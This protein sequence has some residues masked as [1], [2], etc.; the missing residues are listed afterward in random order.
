[1]KTFEQVWAENG[2]QYGEAELELVRLGWEMRNH[3]LS[4][5]VMHAVGRMQ[6]LE[7]ENAMLAAEVDRLKQ[8]AHQAAEHLDCT[9]LYAT[10]YPNDSHPKN[11]SALLV[12]LRNEVG[13]K[14]P[15]RTQSQFRDGF[16]LPPYPHRPS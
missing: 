3:T 11:A 5:P 1:M 10:G 7:D 2:R 9:L 12:E 15:H 14:G 13:L 6:E 4:V 8:V 16:I